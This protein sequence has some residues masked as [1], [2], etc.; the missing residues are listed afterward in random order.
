MNPFYQIYRLYPIYQPKPTLN[1]TT[2]IFWDWFAANSEP[3]TMLDDLSEEERRKLLDAMS[4]QLELYCPGLTYEIGGKTPQG[5]RL[6][7]SAEGDM[8]LFGAVIALVDEAPDI[9]WWEFVAFKQ[10]KGKDLKVVF[11]KYRFETAKMYFMQLECEEEPEALGLR[12]AVPG[13]P[14]NY[15]PD[16]PDEEDRQVG[17]YVTVE[18]LVGEFDCATVIG[19][20]ELCPTPKEPLKEGFTPLDDLPVMMEWFK[21]KTHRDATPEKN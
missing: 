15:N 14:P 19:Y 9:D 8:E 21:R 2:N 11:D 3:L 17:V 5:R 10:S 13:L 16:A 4:H 6:T 7:F 20:L 18:A 1:M 12:I